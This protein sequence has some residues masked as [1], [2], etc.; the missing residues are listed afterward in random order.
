MWFLKIVCGGSFGADNR[1]YEFQLRTN[2]REDKEKALEEALRKLKK[3]TT[4]Y[5]DYYKPIV[6]K[7]K[8]VWEEEFELPFELPKKQE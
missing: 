8:L 1:L 5:D 7:P 2:R 3:L 6:E 4:R